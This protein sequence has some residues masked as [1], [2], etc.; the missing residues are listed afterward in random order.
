MTYETILTILV[1]QFQFPVR[2]VESP[3]VNVQ[4][5]ESSHNLPVHTDTYSNTILCATPSKYSLDYCVRRP[6]GGCFSLDDDG[7]YPRRLFRD[8]VLWQHVQV[9]RI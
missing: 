8:E 7:I 3:E 4:Q 6:A 5:G 2:P 9:I 1:K